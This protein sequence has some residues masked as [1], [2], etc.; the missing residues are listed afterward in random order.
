[1]VLKGN[2]K[3]LCDH[4]KYIYNINIQYIKKLFFRVFSVSQVCIS[5]YINK[6]YKLE[7]KNERINIYIL[8]IGI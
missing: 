3:C 8:G 7:T 6:L 1:M 5:L 4:S 2:S